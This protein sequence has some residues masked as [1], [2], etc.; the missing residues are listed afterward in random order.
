MRIG[1]SVLTHAGQNIWENGLGQN[2]IFLAQAFQRLP[3]VESV[4]L[5]NGGDQ[6]TMPPQVNM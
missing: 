2:V 1:I 3:F 5:L 6:Q 4:V